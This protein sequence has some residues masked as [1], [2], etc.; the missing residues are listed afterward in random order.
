MDMVH[1]LVRNDLQMNSDRLLDQMRII[2][3]SLCYYY[4]LDRCHSPH[5]N[6]RRM[7]RR[8]LMMEE[9]L[10]VD[11]ANHRH[12]LMRMLVVGVLSLMLTE[13]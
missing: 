13:V 2:E 1:P 4:L 8:L 10:W 11:W 5:Q 7:D 3:V 6:L 12:W 9:E